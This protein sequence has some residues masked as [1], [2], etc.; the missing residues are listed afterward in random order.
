MDFAR[1]YDQQ[2]ERVV[3]TDDIGDTV[4]EMID[5]GV[6][7]NDYAGS[8]GIHQG[9]TKYLDYGMGVERYDHGIGEKIVRD[10]EWGD[11]DTDRPEGMM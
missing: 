7:P 11:Y 10:D 8:F 3:D 2:G 1:C 9:E 6:Y 5:A 4:D